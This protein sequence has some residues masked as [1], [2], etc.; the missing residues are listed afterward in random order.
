MVMGA[1]LGT[2]LVGLLHIPLFIMDN[3]KYAKMERVQRAMFRL[4][5]KD[6]GLTEEEVD[7]ACAKLDRRIND[8]E[9]V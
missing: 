6:A 1:G 9:A 5:L 7:I 4:R 2:V 8:P 3:R